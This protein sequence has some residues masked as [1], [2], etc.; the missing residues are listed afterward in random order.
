MKKLKIFFTI[1]GFIFFLLAAYYYTTDDNY[2]TGKQNKYTVNIDDDLTI[3][4]KHNPSTGVE[5]KWINSNNCTFIELV[6][7]EYETSLKERLG[8]DGAGGF[9]YWKF[10]AKGKG[11]DTIKFKNIKIGQMENINDSF[12]NESADI[13]VIMEVK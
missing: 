10:K 6:D 2:I 4:L 13:E 3:K 12:K 5:L 1:I 9:S 11:I 7:K 8:Y